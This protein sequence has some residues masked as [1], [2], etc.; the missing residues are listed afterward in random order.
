MPFPDNS[1]G[2]IFASYVPA[3]YEQEAYR[4]LEPGGVLVKRGMYGFDIHRREDFPTILD[5]YNS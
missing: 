5:K 1:I 3:R 4:V 2:A